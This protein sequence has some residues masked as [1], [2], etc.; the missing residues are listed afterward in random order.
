MFC[1]QHTGTS[2]HGGLGAALEVGVVIGVACHYWIPV[3]NGITVCQT[4]KVAARVSCVQPVSRGICS[5]GLCAAHSIARLL[6]LSFRADWAGWLLC[7]PNDGVHGVQLALGEYTALLPGRPWDT[8][9]AP[10]HSPASR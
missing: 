1:S 10:P 5:L 7:V 2:A 6:L 4:T 9:P 8:P 3:L